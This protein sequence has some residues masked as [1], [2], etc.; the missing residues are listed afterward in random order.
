MPPIALVV[1]KE[2]LEEHLRARRED[3][4]SFLASELAIWKQELDDGRR[5][6]PGIAQASD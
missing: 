3:S 5:A 4:F 6:V 2:A 1:S